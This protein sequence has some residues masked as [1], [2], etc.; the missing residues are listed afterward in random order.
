V[1]IKRKEERR[2]NKLKSC[3]SVPKQTSR[4]SSRWLWVLAGGCVL[5][6]IFALLLP[7]AARS[8][9]PLMIAAEAHNSKSI[10]DSGIAGN[11]AW[12]APRRWNSAA[13]PG[14]PQTAEQIVAVKVIQ[15]GRKRREMVREIAR[16]LNKAAPPE[17]ERFFDAIESGN[18]DQIHAQWTEL[19]KRSGQYEYST[20]RSEEL[21]PFWAAVLDA[22]GVAEQAHLWPAQKLLD[23]G[24][25][26]L[27]SLRPGMVYVGGTD[28]GRWI[29]ELLNETG[30]GEPHIIVTQNALADSRYLDFV[31]TLYGGQFVALSQDETQ[32]A[33]Q[34]YEQ[35]A[36]KRL[37]HDQQFSDEPKQLQPGENV[38]E[39]D[40]KV[41][42]SGQVA[43]M[44]INERLLQALM[45]KNPDLPFALQESFPLK[46][47]YAE[48]APLGPIMELRAQ[49]GQAAF[50][51]ERA[52]QTLDY[53]QTMT[54]QL[55]GEPADPDSSDDV[56]KAYSHD[57]VAAAN[58]LAAHDYNG[59]AKEVY[60]LA[61]RQCPYNP[62]PVIHLSELLAR[63]GGADEARQLLDDFARKYPDQRAAVESASIGL[64][65]R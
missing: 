46:S 42:V 4:Q 7:R 48:A 64:K 47:T 5:V 54:Q 49:S 45:Q 28:N 29:P 62:E 30:D 41:Q 14:P 51:A 39:V 32:H 17:V 1:S 56:R 60:R 22:Y 53:W 19:A 21:N 40:G 16:R 36:Q 59:E 57:T 43:V 63:T 34:D 18:W 12:P 31:S 15:F 55:L 26:V 3:T 13:D 37:Q 2:M 58:L 50:T 10:A 20:D 38:R 11:R 25:A 65:L 9:A 61:S 6:L 35:D 33:F 24:N 23:Y 8:P 52:T 44:A 27:D